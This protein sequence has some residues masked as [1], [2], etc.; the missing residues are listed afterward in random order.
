MGGRRVEVEVVV[1]CSLVHMIEGG[2]ISVLDTT[3]VVL[4]TCEMTAS[5][6]FSWDCPYRQTW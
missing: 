3:A 5:R 4:S 6:R 2:G 1:R